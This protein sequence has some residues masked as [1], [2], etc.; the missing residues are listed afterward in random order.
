[1]EGFNVSYLRMIL[2]TS[3][4]SRLHQKPLCMRGE[5]IFATVVK[6]VFYTFS[7]RAQV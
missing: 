3:A 4:L 1:M 5:T 2:F 7:V 6:K